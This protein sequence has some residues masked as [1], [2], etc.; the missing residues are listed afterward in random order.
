MPS[1]TDSQD[2]KGCDQKATAVNQTW[3]LRITIEPPTWA[4]P[5][6]VC[7]VLLPTRFARRA[8]AV[9]AGQCLW[10]APPG[11]E[12]ETFHVRAVGA[13]AGKGPDEDVGDQG[14]QGDQEDEGDWVEVP[15]DHTCG[16]I[17]QPEQDECGDGC[18]LTPS[19]GD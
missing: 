6:A 5:E 3:M 14:D 13:V 10:A 17:L 7:H 18:A 9:L 11:R 12:I 4:G 1:A 16:A 15:W 19:S 2:N 8:E